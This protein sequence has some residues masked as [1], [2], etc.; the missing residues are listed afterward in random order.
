MEKQEIIKENIR[1]SKRKY[2]QMYNKLN[3]GIQLNRELIQNLR[4]KIGDEV[5]VKSYIEDL[6]KQQL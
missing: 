2:G 5:S 6:I 3:I 4:N 1:K